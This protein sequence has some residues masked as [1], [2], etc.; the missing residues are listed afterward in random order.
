MSL[1]GTKENIGMI[2]W[3]DVTGGKADTQIGTDE[4][5]IQGELNIFCLYESVEEKT[6]WINRTVPYEGR[7]ECMGT[8]PGM[9]HQA[10][11]NLT[12]V[13]VEARMDENGEMRILG[14]EATLEVRLVV[15]EEEKSRFLK[16]C[17]C[18][19]MSAFRI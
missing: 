9:Y 14:I 17:I 18:W 16:I 3:T 1:N 2:L 4:L 10:S 19:I 8:V 7:I 5:L 15:Y 13:N 6:D 12:D 11:L